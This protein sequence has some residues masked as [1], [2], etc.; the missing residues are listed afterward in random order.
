MPRLP[1]YDDEDD[2]E[3]FQRLI[4]D[5]SFGSSDVEEVEGP[6]LPMAPPPSDMPR[7]VTRAQR[8]ADE[9]QSE[10]KE[11]SFSTRPRG[12]AR[13]QRERLAAILDLLLKQ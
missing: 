8:E 9:D 4:E 1:Y 11:L 12:K 13:S 2:D 10:L 6:F 5:Q 3:H 7:R